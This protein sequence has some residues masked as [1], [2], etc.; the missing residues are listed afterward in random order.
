MK[1]TE[2]NRANGNCLHGVSSY[3]D[4]EHHRGYAVPAPSHSPKGG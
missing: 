1:M 3:G 4:V 2:E